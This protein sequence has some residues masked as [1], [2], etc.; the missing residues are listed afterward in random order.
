MRAI[1]IAA[2]AAALAVPATAGVI[3]TLENKGGGQIK[4]TDDICKSREGQDLAWLFA[5]STLPGGKFLTG[6]WMVA[7]DDVLV[8]YD[9]GGVRLYPMDAFTTRS[10]SS[11]PS[12]PKKPSYRNDL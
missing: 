5:Y 6:C 7:D 11:S 9:N 4:L 2:L 10:K 1:L 12:K 3:A 8:I